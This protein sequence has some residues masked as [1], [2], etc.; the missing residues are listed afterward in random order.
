M[1][2]SGQRDH[3]PDGRGATKRADRTRGHEGDRCLRQQLGSGQGS[4]PG[5]Q[6]IAGR[7]TWTRHSAPISP[8]RGGRKPIDITG[9]E[10]PSIYRNTIA[11][12]LSDERINALILGYWHTI[13]TP[14]MPLMVFACLVAEVVG[15]FGASGSPWW[16]R[17]PAMSRPGRASA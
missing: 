13:V 9:G 12:G 5:G 3:R 1:R 14:V 6:G 15:E 17:S 2:P 7:R 4:A 8:A 11:L 16:P 10:P